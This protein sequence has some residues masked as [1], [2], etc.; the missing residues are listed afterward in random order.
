MAEATP[1][2]RARFGALLQE[3]IQRQGTQATK[4]LETRDLETF[5]RIQAERSRTLQPAWEG[6]RLFVSRDE[7]GEPGLPETGLRA[8][9]ATR[10]TPQERQEAFQRTFPQGQTRDAIDEFGSTFRVFRR[11]EAEPWRKLDPNLFEKWEPLQDVADFAGDVGPIIG[12][13]ATTRGAGGVIRQSIRAAGGAAAG[14][15]AEEAG[16]TLLGQQREGIGQILATA[17]LEGMAAGVGTAATAPLSFLMNVKHGVA[18][19][20]L[21]PGAR[22]ALEAEARQGLPQLTAPQLAVSPMLRRTG[23]YGE[24]F[25]TAMQQHVLDQNN[26][27]AGR[28]QELGLPGASDLPF[29][30]RTGVQAREAELL[31]MLERPRAT[32]S[33]DWQQAG[34]AFQEGLQEWDRL[35]RLEVDDLH[36]T[37]RA[38]EEPQFDYADLQQRAQVGLDEGV[39]LKGGGDAR[40]MSPMAGE[41]RAVLQDIIAFD[42]SP[43]TITLPDGT[44]AT[45]SP[46]DQLRAFRER[47]W[48]LKTVD[49]GTI[50]RRPEADAGHFYSQITKVLEKPQ[51]SPDFLAAWRT[52]SDAARNRFDIWDST[53]IRTVDRAQDVDSLARNYMRPGQRHAL[54]TIKEVIPG[55]NWNAFREAAINDIMADPQNISRRLAEFDEPTINVVLQPREKAIIRQIGE[56][57]DRLTEARALMDLPRWR[58]MGRAVLNAADARTAVSMGELGGI[59]SPSGR[60]LRAA[61]LNQVIEDVVE[62]GRRGATVNRTALN[63]ILA[64]VR[65]N[66]ADQFL[67]ASDIEVLT[68]IHKYLD[69][70]GTEGGDMGAS[71]MGSQQQLG[72]LREFSTGALVNI[73]QTVGM[74]DFLI[75]PAGRRLFIGRGGPRPTYNNLRLMGAAVGT[76]ISDFEESE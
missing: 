6:T 22:D 40:P 43:K 33:R 25:S 67:A 50:A 46:T 61:I 12:E 31:E 52:A 57:M 47:L 28:I 32:L 54:Q 51:G 70:A 14:H 66:G 55:Q 68:D 1:E 62:Q 18:N 71:L 49:P 75:S 35:A 8:S 17:G 9:L 30:T 45:L 48:D 60:R 38:I 63:R 58:D 26:A 4:A 11:D 73:A 65:D 72:M 39:I 5:Q 13:A 76:L 42:G 44:T 3:H 21:M 29:Y 19:A 53:V 37:A 20:A 10:E 64:K 59:H 16:E 2:E 69:F 74:G 7:L 23:T 34:T 24:T 41:L 56:G 27:A 36:T 15:I